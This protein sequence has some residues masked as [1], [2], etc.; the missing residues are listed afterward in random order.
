[1][2]WSGKR[3]KDAKKAPKMRRLDYNKKKSPRQ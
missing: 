2:E 3:A 1:V